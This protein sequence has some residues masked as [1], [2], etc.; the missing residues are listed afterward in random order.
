M[1]VHSLFDVRKF[2]FHLRAQS[3]ALAKQS[4]SVGTM[5]LFLHCHDI[6]QLIDELNQPWDRP[7][8]LICDMSKLVDLDMACREISKAKDPDPVRIDRYVKDIITL[9][10]HWKRVQENRWT[11]KNI[12]PKV[13]DRL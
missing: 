4:R 8:Y 11:T 10:L 12:L 7:G 5:R 13:Q 6:F 1:S 3:F 2:V 9:L